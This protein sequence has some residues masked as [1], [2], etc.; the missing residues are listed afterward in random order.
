MTMK[1]LAR[2]QFENRS[3][4]KE[5]NIIGTVLSGGYSLVYN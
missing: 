4:V 2:W 3:R 5:L 1:W